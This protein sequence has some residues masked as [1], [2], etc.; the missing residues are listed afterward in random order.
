MLD[1]LD[2]RSPD[3]V[4]EGLI[5]SDQAAAIRRYEHAGEEAVP[6]R[7]T[8]VAEVAIYLG[9]LI[10]L[11]GGA[12]IIGPNWRSL[13]FV[14]QIVL[15]VA[16][17]AVG[18]AV[19][20]S[21]VRQAEPG[22]LRVGTFLWVVGTGGMAL[23]TGVVMH[24]IDPADDAWN[25]LV[26]GA[27]VAVLGI[28]LWRNLDR[29]LQWLTAV[30]GVVM[31]AAGVA[32]LVDVSVWVGASVVWVTG[33]VVGVLAAT[34]RMR[35]RLVGLA[36]GASAMMLA[37]FVIGDRSEW[38]SAVA[39][40]GTAAGIV[41]FALADRSWPLVGLGLFAF[42]LAITMAMQTVLEGMAARLVAVA[43]GL[44]LVA[45][46]AVRAQRSARSAHP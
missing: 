10:A 21:L 7:L 11:A 27:V 25:V 35:P 3:W 38:V 14:G 45:V 2:R 36:V 19:G 31:V 30:T 33:L 8:V 23:A 17:A 41:T 12:A 1:W 4:A 15:G 13:G 34:G 29:P 22:T 43:A 9:S 6:P 39:A 37:A 24:E 28:A 18:F 20:S 5:S 16:I 32:Q 40:L 26:I 44:V 46:V 42:F